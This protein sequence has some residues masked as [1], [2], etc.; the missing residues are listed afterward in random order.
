MDDG[1]NAL[2]DAA[3]EDFQK[4]RRLRNLERFARGGGIGGNLKFVKCLSATAVGGNSVLAQCY[5]AQIIEPA[6]DYA[7]APEDG[8]LCL[9]SLMTDRGVSVKPAA[10]RVYL[11]LVTGDVE[12]DGSGSLAG[13][14]RAFG[15]IG[16]PTV[17]H[18][19]SNGDPTVTETLL[20][21]PSGDS[22]TDPVIQRVVEND[23][24]GAGTPRITRSAY[25][26]GTSGGTGVT[27]TLTP[28]LY[29]LVVDLATGATAGYSASVSGGATKIV[30]FGTWDFS[31]AALVGIASASGTTDK[32]AKFTGGSALG[33]SSITDNGGTVT[34]TLPIVAVSSLTL[35]YVAGTDNY[36]QTVGAGAGSA[37]LAQV[38]RDTSSTLLGTISCAASTSVFYH[39]IQNGSFTRGNVYYS[40]VDATGTVAGGSGTTG[41]LTFVGGLYVSG[42]LSVAIGGVS[43]LGTGVATFLATPSSANL[44]AALTDETG[45]AGSVVFSVSPAFTGTPTA[46]TASAGN[47]TTQIATTAFVTDA[48][49]T[50]VTGLLEF[51][52][53]TDCS[54]NP[55]Y[56]SASKGDA[57]VVSVAG[58]IGGASGKS[59]DVGDMYLATADNAGGTE[60]SVG[61]SWTV[62]EHN[63]VGALLSANNLSDLASASTARTNLGGTTVGGNLFT[64][65]NPSAVAFVRINADNTVTARSAANFRADLGLDTGDNPR[66]D[67][68]ELGAAS[69]TTISRV[70]AGVIAVEGATVRTGTVAETVG[71]TNQTAYTLGDLLYA[72]ASNTLSKLA[73]NTTTTLKFL[74][75][76][77]T[78]TVSAAP[79]WTT[80]IGTANLPGG[81]WIGFTNTAGS[82][83]FTLSAASGTYQA[84]GITF[85]C[86]ASGKYF[87]S[88]Q[89]RGEIQ[90]NAAGVHFITAKL[91][92]QTGPTDLADINS[93]GSEVEVVASA[94]N[95][96]YAANTCVLSG[97]FDLLSGS[98]YE[99]YAKRNGTAWATS[100]ISND[101]NG[102]TKITAFR[103]Y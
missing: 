79:A 11:C 5:P 94:Q 12:S 32:V 78:G 37:S 13:R 41:G 65:T 81:Q 6:A 68:I 4:L 88:A 43:G 62:L 66:F 84:T 20:A 53:S 16:E 92:N 28:T 24:D 89:L 18:G 50:A 83:S 46:P 102:R 7:L 85:T 2:S 93:V 69:D 25:T 49:G 52:G 103:I 91:M 96:I 71:G 19:E 80:T 90:P 60:A 30:P 31:S 26:D 87:I 40:I 10:N 76:T 101:T 17:A 72:S 56:P 22:T 45:T 82:G 100:Q 38:F 1:V 57:Y 77:G 54:A 63:L 97:I 61:T 55:N 64:L 48:V 3:A 95:G 23:Y 8:A 51:K 73:G 74:G 21:D 39:Q 44:A 35:Q 9:L 14:A 33:N 67:T 47:N 99:I 98:T 86:N 58:K 70:S 15:V 27:E 42:S 75:Q 36:V 34:T 59:V 29:Q